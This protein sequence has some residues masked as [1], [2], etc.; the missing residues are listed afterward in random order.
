MQIV[1]DCLDNPSTSC[2][3]YTSATN[4]PVMVTNMEKCMINW[5]DSTCSTRYTG[6]DSLPVT[7]KNVDE[8]LTDVTGT[9]TRYTSTSSIPV[10]GKNVDLCM[11]D[12][13]DATCTSEYGTL[14]TST[15]PGNGIVGYIQQLS[16]ISLTTLSEVK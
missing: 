9:C 15:T 5:K 12:I 1:N 14:L 16:K 13:D 11:K 3:S 6:T 10:I 8:C 2:S 7:V 4:L